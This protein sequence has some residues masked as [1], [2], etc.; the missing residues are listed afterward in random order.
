VIGASDDEYP[1]RKLR[2][3]Q[4]CKWATRSGLDAVRSLAAAPCGR[5]GGSGDVLQELNH[6]CSWSGSAVHGR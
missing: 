2:R 1:R 6:G 3:P 4:D 5:A